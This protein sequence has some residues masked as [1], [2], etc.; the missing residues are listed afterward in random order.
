MPE[1][2]RIKYGPK[3]KMKDGWIDLG[4]FLK[5]DG[6]NVSFFFASSNSKNFHS[7]FFAVG[8]TEKKEEAN[9][10]ID[11]SPSTRMRKAVKIPLMKNNVAVEAGDTLKLYKPKQQIGKAAPP[12]RKVAGDEGLDGD[13]PGP[14]PKK[15]KCR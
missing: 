3:D 11:G 8:T 15:S 13:M 4:A 14:A 6:K 7:H 1:T 5:F 12:L 2:F 9:M 10:V